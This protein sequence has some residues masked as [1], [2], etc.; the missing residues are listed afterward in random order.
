MLNEASISLVI[1][2]INGGRSNPQGGDEESID[3]QSP[4][5]ARA[6]H[7]SAEDCQLILAH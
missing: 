6:Q 2:V 7:R 1:D 4:L 5:P 3:R